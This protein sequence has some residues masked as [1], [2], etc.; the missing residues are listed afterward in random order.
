[1]IINRIGSLANEVLTDNIAGRA[2]QSG[3]PRSGEE[4]GAHATLSSG[5]VAVGSLVAQVMR[6]P[7]IRQAKVDGLRASVASGNY[8]I[9][10][11]EIASALIRDRIG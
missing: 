10:T 2:N 11:Q 7:A 1:M 9:D 6:T 5:T 3:N 8:P 4:S